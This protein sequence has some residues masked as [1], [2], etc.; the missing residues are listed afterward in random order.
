VNSPGGF[1]FSAIAIDENGVVWCASG[2]EGIFSLSG[3]E[4]VTFTRDDG[5]N[6]MNYRSV[7]VDRTNQKWFGSAGGGV[8]IIDDSGGDIQLAVIDTTDGRL[9]GSDTPSYVIV[10]D[11]IVDASGNIWIANKFAWN[12]KPLAVVSPEGDWQY[13][14]A[15]DGI[16]DKA[17]SALA[18]DSRGWKWVGTELDGIVVLDD[19]GTPFDKND[20]VIRGYLTRDDGL[21][22]NAIRSIAIDSDDVVWI[23][24]DSGLNYWYNNQ[25]SSRGGLLSLDVNCIKIDFRNNKWIGTKGGVSVLSSDS[26]SWTH[27]TTE[28]HPLVGDNVI[29]FAFDPNTGYTYIGTES[30]LSRLETPYTPPR[31]DLSEVVGYPNPFMPLSDENKFTVKNLAD[32]STIRFFTPDGLLI[33]TIMR[34]EIPGSWAEWDGRNEN[35]DYVASGV[36][37][38]VIY[39]EE[40]HSF[41]GKVAVIR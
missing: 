5:L 20:D 13:F 26:Y 28:T 12:N 16:M 40:K 19:G 9:S 17:I 24:T 1:T 37:V 29:S 35:G 33:K 10:E 36:Y 21:N 22:S 25:V 8:T 27:Y 14:T 4:W 30:G 41:V 3:G 31:A 11:M 7:V 18:I 2:S 38:F 23:G 39:T 15:S 32:G 34:E 6:S